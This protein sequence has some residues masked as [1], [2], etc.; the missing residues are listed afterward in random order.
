MQSSEGV[1]KRYVPTSTSPEQ[2]VSKLNDATGQ[3][4]ALNG[5]WSPTIFFND[6]LNFPVRSK[7]KLAEQVLYSTQKGMDYLEFFNTSRG[8][9]REVRHPKVWEVFSRGSVM[10]YFEPLFLKL[11]EK[12]D[13]T[14]DDL[15]IVQYLDALSRTSIH[16]WDSVVEG[17]GAC[18]WE[19]FSKDPQA[20]AKLLRRTSAV[21]AEELTDQELIEG[22]GFHFTFV[23]R[24]LSRAHLIK[25]YQSTRSTDDMSVSS[26]K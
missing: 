12:E 8:H 10:L 20:Y 9:P 4:L 14:K 13:L 11:I 24:D 1:Q 6:L 2:L 16:Q 7:R 3:L 15:T 23:H 18:C 26:L 17:A 5:T 21:R 19:Y 25:M 22:S